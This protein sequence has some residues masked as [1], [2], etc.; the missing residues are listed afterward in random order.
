MA[1]V[2]VEEDGAIATITLDHP[3][4][5]NALSEALIGELTRAFDRLR[6]RAA[7]AVVLRARPGA[8]V[9][10][11]GHDVDELPTSPRDP[12][13]WSYPLR[14]LVRRL[15]E[16]PAPVIALVEGG[17]WG[18]ACEVVFACD[19]INA[20]PDA[21]FAITPARLG[22]PYNVTGLKSLV[23]ALPVA[24]VKE[25]IYTARPLGVER[26]YQLGAVNHIVP[27]D[28]ITAFTTDQA[29]TIAANASLTI[30]AMKEALRILADAQ[31]LAP[32][33][34]ERLQDLRRQVGESRDY[35]EGL[36]AFA[37]KRPPVFRGD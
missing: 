36:Q 34:F 7:R 2:S 20:T 18:G 37:E 8:R 22:V 26:L 28:H 11:A 24:V 23:A 32:T 14:T 13:G 30:A 12:L 15:Q 9:W 31:S 19:L 10:S 4:K 6:E 16:F 33:Q 29:R 17:V 27:G 35:R 5:R 3:E 1:L 25:M 21:T